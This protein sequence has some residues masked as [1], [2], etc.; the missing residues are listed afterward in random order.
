MTIEFWVDTAEEY[1]AITNA[2]LA[3]ELTARDV[4]F[5]R[6]DPRACMTHR[7]APSTLMA[8]LVASNEARLRLALI[9][10]LL[11]HPTFTKDADCA[12]Q[13][14]LASGQVTFKCYYTAAQLLQQKHQPRL[15]ALLGFYQPLPDLYG[16]E[17]EILPLTSPDNGLH[18]LAER[19]RVLSGRPI[20]WYGTYEHAVQRWLAHT[21]QRQ[22]WN[23]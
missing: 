23:L 6:S 3:A 17:L 9:P 16:R 15:V 14:L 20:N 11:R 4:H 19:H 1:I 7:L 21:E 12:R 10:L 22:R 18:K 13:V 5:L 8:A 2:Q